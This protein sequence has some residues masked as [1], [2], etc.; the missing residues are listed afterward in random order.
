ME[1]V[2]RNDKIETH[3]KSWT[4]H[5]DNCTSKDKGI[6]CFPT[7]GA[8]P[9]PITTFK[10]ARH[11]HTHSP[12]VFF[13]NLYVERKGFLSQGVPP[14]TEEGMTSCQWKLASQRQEYLGLA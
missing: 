9:A 7:L 13:G 3:A 10:S 8:E 2:T 6:L 12:R 5:L 14:G 11:S 1:T 4:W